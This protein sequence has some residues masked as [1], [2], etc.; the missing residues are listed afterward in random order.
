[1]ASKSIGVIRGTDSGNIFAIV[2]PDEDEELDNPRLLL[3][4][5]T[6]GYNEPLVMIKLEREQYMRCTTQEE[7]WTLVG[8]VSDWSQE[9]EQKE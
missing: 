4:R 8:S 9:Q 6:S 1:M 2:N 3:L 7:V 5:H